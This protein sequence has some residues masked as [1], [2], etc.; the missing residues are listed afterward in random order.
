MTRP[1]A[2]AT[3][4][5]AA[6]RRR[7]LSTR[8][9][10]YG[11]V[12]PAVL[13]VALL[14]YAPFLWSAYLSFTRY[15]GLT[16]ARWIGLANYRKLFDDPVL[17]TSIRNTLLWVVGSLLLP[18]GIGLLIAVLTYD[19]RG[20]RWFRLPFL[21]PYALSGAGIGV[22]WGFLLQPDGAL[23]SV[24]RTLHLPGGHTSLLQ[25][26]PWNTVVMILAMTWQGVG[27]TLLLF[28]VG[29]QS[30]PRAPLEAARIDGAT[31]WTLFRRIIWPLLRP[32]TTVVVGL[33][34]VA[35][36]K[37]FDV[38][39][40]MTAGGPGR[41]SETLAVTMYKDTFVANDYG[42]GSTVAVMLCVITGLV[43]VVYLRQQLRPEKTANTMGVG[44]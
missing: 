13:L 27:V 44:K 12:S 14:L 30:I 19:I 9:W 39:W 37:T 41:S 20:G 33:Q 21:M 28:V 7:P 35:S 6:T 26:G 32:L 40:V 4:P 2:A 5:A 38:V 29:L 15:D 43:S 22:I 34:L 16:P 24:L 31:G 36:L 18:V 8:L 11:M 10:P 23:N 1:V 3:Q 42:Y 17:T 25:H